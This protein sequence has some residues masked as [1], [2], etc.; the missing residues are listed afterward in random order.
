MQLIE[1]T[2][3]RR[4]GVTEAMIPSKSLGF[5]KTQKRRKNPTPK[6]VFAILGSMI[7]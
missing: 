1:S 3:S 7:Y 2:V 5:S 4:I 6:F